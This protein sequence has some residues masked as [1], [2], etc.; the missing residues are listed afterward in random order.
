MTGVLGP[1][2]CGGFGVGGVLSWGLNKE[3]IYCELYC[4]SNLYRY[5][6]RLQRYM[7]KLL[8]SDWSSGVQL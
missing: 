6:S 3:D 8:Y 1:G 5:S 7:T 4:S 2:D